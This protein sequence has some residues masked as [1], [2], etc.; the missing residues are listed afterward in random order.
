MSLRE[1]R[2]G[3]SAEVHPSANEE[4]TLR[5][6]PKSSFALTLNTHPMFK[7]LQGLTHRALVRIHGQF[8]SKAA[9]L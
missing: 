6:W 2:P 5:A 7:M 9:P 8:G 3:E 1:L 4:L